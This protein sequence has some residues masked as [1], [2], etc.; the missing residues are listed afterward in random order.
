MRPGIFIFA[1]MSQFFSR[2]LPHRKLSSL[3]ML[4][5]GRRMRFV[6]GSWSTQDVTLRRLGSCPLK[7]LGE[8]FPIFFRISADKLTHF[9]PII[10]SRNSFHPHFGCIFFTLI[11]W[12]HFSFNF[13]LL[14][15]AVTQITHRNYFYIIFPFSRIFSLA[16]NT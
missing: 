8:N 13:F 2:Y 6:R 10:G 5:G 12:V 16:S 4:K 7:A 3:G 1:S 15:I 9:I 11:F 14:F